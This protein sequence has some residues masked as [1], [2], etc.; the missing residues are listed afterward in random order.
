M[1]KLIDT[2]LGQFRLVEDGTKK[3]FLFECPECHEMLPMD[4]EILA[5][6]KDIQHESRILPATYCR[7]MGMREFGKHLIATM[8][9]QIV[10]GYKPYHDEGQD[11]L[12]LEGKR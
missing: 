4:E 6:R 9:A 8:Q 11:Q 10:M 12:A 5:G 7:F 2:E 1:S 3:W